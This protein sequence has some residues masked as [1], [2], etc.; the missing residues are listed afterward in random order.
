[1][2]KIIYHLADNKDKEEV[3]SLW[4]Y[5]FKDTKE[6]VDL[7]FE[8]CYKTE[9]TVGAYKNTQLL[10]AAQLN[11]YTIYLRG[12]KI[13][14]DYVVGVETA[15]EAR[16]EGLA[17]GLMQALLEESI[18]RGRY[19]SILMPFSTNFY[20]SYGWRFCYQQLRYNIL[21]GEL[22]PVG[23]NY[24]MIKR[25]NP[26]KEIGALDE[27]YRQ[28]CSYYHGY[29]LRSQANWEVM[30]EDLLQSGGYCALLIG[31]SNE[32][33]GYVLYSFE[34]E[35]INV[36]ELAYTNYKAKGGLLKYL[37]RHRSQ[38]SKINLPLPI[39]D[40]S[41]N[42]L[43]NKQAAVIYPFM[44]ARIADVAKLLEQLEY[45][46]DISV[47]IKVNDA[48]M[49]NNNNVFTLSIKDG[50]GQ[51]AISEGAY[52]LQIDI[53]EL[54]ALVLGATDSQALRQAGKITVNNEAA[55]E[56]WQMLWSKKNNFINEY[57]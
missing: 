35:T 34:Q 7:Y 23:L 56:H 25:L 50:Q 13:D 15:P 43:E 54:T 18:K 19:L 49:S 31:E 24:G 20:Y 37:Y 32:P 55:F 4:Q 57:F 28:F 29:P 16:G 41:F 3:K 53:S 5:C 52:D 17:G 6:F 26:L 14:V 27:I 8:K 39:D 36:L 9:N 42:F 11:P 46:R 38:F 12:K 47:K 21:L 1:M 33:E 40:T 51:I 44:M 48:L 30:L 10:A 2:E 45:E 22:K